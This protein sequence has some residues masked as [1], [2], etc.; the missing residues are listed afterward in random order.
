MILHVLVFF[1]KG[2]GAV[3]RDGAVIRSF[4]VFVYNMWH[5]YIEA[6]WIWISLCVFV[7][8]VNQYI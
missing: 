7:P 6:F 5:I 2:G 3:I 8:E 1:S 4:M